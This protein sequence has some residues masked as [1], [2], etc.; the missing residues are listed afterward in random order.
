MIVLAGLASLVVSVFGLL[1]GGWGGFLGGHGRPFS[2]TVIFFWLTPALCL[3]AFCTTFLYRRVGLVWL[4]MVP[5]GTWLA[6]F[7]GTWQSCAEGECTTTNPVSIALGA[8]VGLG[9]WPVI[10]VAPICMQIAMSRK[11]TQV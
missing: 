7:I 4:W 3:P 10:W 9:P 5:V 2:L 11:S 8:L 6:L 1:A